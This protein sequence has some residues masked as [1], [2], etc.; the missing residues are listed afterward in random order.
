MIPINLNASLFFVFAV[1]TAAVPLLVLT[2]KSKSAA[3]ISFSVLCLAVCLWFSGLSGMFLNI[4]SGNE[5]FW[6]KISFIGMAFIAVLLLRFIYAYSKTLITEKFF[7]FFYLLAAA[8]ILLNFYN[9]LFYR[10]AVKLFHFGFHH[11]QSPLFL[12]IPLQLIIF[13][14]LASKSLKQYLRTSDLTAFKLR[15]ISKIRFALALF[16]LVAA[17]Q[18]LSYFFIHAYLIG[19]LSAVAFVAI[20]VYVLG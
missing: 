12:L 18:V 10:E 3:N 11:K 16:F 2:R 4:S 9:G 8:V 6:E 1:F 7:I 20:T 14:I 17:D 15:Q 5:L 19:S 13:T